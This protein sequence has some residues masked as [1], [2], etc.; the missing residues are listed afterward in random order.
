MC[1]TT[2]AHTL[3]MN[4]YSEWGLAKF[5]ARPHSAFKYPYYHFY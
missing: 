2:D 3:Y 1:I 5:G 4:D